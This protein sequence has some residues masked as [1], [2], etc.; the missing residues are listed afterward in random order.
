LIAPLPGNAPQL[1]ALATA[2]PAHLIEQHHAAEM[3]RT[4]FGHRLAGY[5]AF[6]R[7]FTSTGVEQRY[8]V[9][10]P[11]WFGE[12]HNWPDRTAAYMSGASKLYADVV[13]KALAAAGLDAGQ[14]DAVITVSSTGVATPSLESRVLPQL[15]FRSDVRRIPVFGLGCAGGV[16]GFAIAARMAASEPG[17][18]VLLVTI[19][20]CTLAFRLDRAT[21]ADIVSAALFGDGAAAAIFRCGE[22]PAIGRFRGATEHLW[23]NTLDIMGWSTDEAGL[24]VILSRS[25][26]TFVA[27]NYRAEFDRAMARLDLTPADID[28]IVCHPGGTKVLEAIETALDIP[29]GA[30][31]IERSV[32]RDFGNMSSPTVLFVLERTLAQGFTGTAVLA[33]LGPGFTASFVTLDVASR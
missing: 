1:L 13:G 11:A 19:E 10:P 21:K 8:S 26:P 25:L 2:L 28:G 29:A 20:L 18:T 15:G 24:G 5:E 4:F 12:T 3:A 14:I 7:V 27:Q 17:S 22:G 6:S 16:S 32:M 23:Q 31:A 9:E 33:A 30:L